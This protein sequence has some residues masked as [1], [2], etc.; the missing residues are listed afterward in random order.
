MLK[1]RTIV[2][3]S[4]STHADHRI[5]RNDGENPAVVPMVEMLKPLTHHPLG[6]FN[7]ST[8]SIEERKPP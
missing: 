4:F 5:A 3:M 7:T 6:A 8:S 2:E 1:I